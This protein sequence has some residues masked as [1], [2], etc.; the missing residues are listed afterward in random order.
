MKSHPR[1]LLPAYAAL[2]AAAVL[3]AA[4]FLGMPIPQVEAAFSTPEWARVTVSVACYALL[5]ATMTFLVAQAYLERR[6]LVGYQRN[7]AFVVLFASVLA[8]AL[9]VGHGIWFS[10]AR[11]GLDYIVYGWRG[12]N[13]EDSWNRRDLAI[14]V[15]RVVAPVV[16]ALCVVGAWRLSI[17]V[18]N[19][20]TR[21]DGVH[22]SYRGRRALAFTGVVTSALLLI[23]HMWPGITPTRFIWARD[24]PL[25]P[26]YGA[27]SVLGW[28]SL[29]TFIIACYVAPHAPAGTRPA[30]ILTFGLGAAAGIQLLHVT[31]IFVGWRHF[32]MAIDDAGRLKDY[33]NFHD[34]Y[35]LSVL[36][37]G[38]AI[39]LP[40]HWV[41]I[42]VMS[43]FAL[44]GKAYRGE[45]RL[46]A[47]P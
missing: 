32:V 3:I 18:F 4:T 39:Q 2:S 13:V 21:R 5:V 14:T 35:P 10:I 25:M 9:A 34:N 6:N 41:V 47:M 15:I 11:S 36:A 17:G 19:G 20:K 40:L 45:D 8:V 43:R 26:V 42:W 30:R 27:L 33:F 31:L 38:Y 16:T 1:A 12:A 37:I 24:I 22:R 44:S 28:I 23:E 29:P 46:Q 7:S